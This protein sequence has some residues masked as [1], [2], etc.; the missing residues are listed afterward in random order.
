MSNWLVNV[1]DA[2][3]ITI[4]W[5]KLFCRNSSKP[6]FKTTV[7]FNWYS[8]I[9]LSKTFTMNHFTWYPIP[10][11]LQACVWSFTSHFSFSRASSSSSAVNISNQV[12]NNVLPRFFYGSFYYFVFDSSLLESAFLSSTVA[13]S[14]ISIVSS[15]YFYIHV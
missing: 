5:T 6:I 13:Q 10:I 7:N 2:R 1:S 9:I 14:T 15:T 4:T 12:I 8:T 11:L 3:F